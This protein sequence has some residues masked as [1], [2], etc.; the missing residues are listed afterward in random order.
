VVDAAVL[1]GVVE[2]S[3]DG[4]VLGAAVGED[5]EEAT[6]RRWLM[7]GMAPPLRACWRWAV[8]A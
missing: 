5:D 1:D 4:L 6:P 3:G 8:E 2:E 7:Y